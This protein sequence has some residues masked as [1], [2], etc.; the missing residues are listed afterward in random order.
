MN[1]DKTEN[2][3]GPYLSGTSTLLST[4]QYSLPIVLIGA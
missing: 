2:H 4:L 1:T 3:S